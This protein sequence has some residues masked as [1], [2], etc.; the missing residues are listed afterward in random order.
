MLFQDYDD[1]QH[2][3]AIG[4]RGEGIIITAE[5]VESNTQY[6]TDYNADDNT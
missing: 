5:D 2:L 6:S 1:K 3:D 4:L